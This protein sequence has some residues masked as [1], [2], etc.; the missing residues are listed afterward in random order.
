MS[1]EEDYEDYEEDDVLS[2]S[3]QI[4]GDIHKLSDIFIEEFP[5]L[6][7]EIKYSFFDKGDL[8][9]IRHKSKAYWNFKFFKKIIVVSQEEI[10]I[11]YDVRKKFFTIDTELKLKDYLKS[12]NKQYLY[13]SINSLP[14]KDKKEALAAIFNQIKETKEMGYIDTLYSIDPTFEKSFVKYTSQY[15]YNQNVDSLGLLNDIFTTSE[16][17]KGFEGKER[18]SINTTIS[19]T[20]NVDEM[21]RAEDDSPD[22]SVSGWSKIKSK[23]SKRR[24]E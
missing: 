21:K 20:I 11:T 16:S 5:H 8:W 17:S 1:K 14:E 6:P 15:G 9:N 12:I 18:K 24:E 22:E 10:K 3:L 2:S 23:F 19:E 13:D 4:G 7:K